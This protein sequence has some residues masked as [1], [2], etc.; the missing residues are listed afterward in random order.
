MAQM[1]VLLYFY[2]TGCIGILRVSGLQDS[3]EVANRCAEVRH[4]RVGG[5]CSISGK[6][7]LPAH[8]TK[9]ASVGNA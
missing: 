5:E 3:A 8:V 7:Q 1:V 2:N 4:F 6:I 9:T